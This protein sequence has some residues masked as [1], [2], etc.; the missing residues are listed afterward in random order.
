MVYN[1]NDLLHSWYE[2]NKEK[3]DIITYGI[4]NKSDIM[5][6][7]IELHKEGSTF[8]CQYNNKEIK[9]EVPVGGIHFVYNAICAISTGL[10][11]NIDIN[12]ILNGIKKFE[13]TKKRMDII[14]LE[15]GV[16]L[17][18]DTY[19]ASF[20]SMEATLKYAENFTENRKIAIL[21]DMLELGEFSK[22]LHEKVGKQVA[23]SKID[24]L[25]CTGE[26]AKS[27]IEGA[28]RYGMNE[29]DTKYFNS[30]KEI[31]DYIKKIW[32]EGDVILV[33]ASNGMKFFEIVENLK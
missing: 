33:K 3:L 26:N 22:E 19:N 9:V 18:N 31:I 30:K 20:E 5:A 15:N 28:K 8:I 7:Q 4:E 27:I 12:D 24:I 23:E 29:K 6:K 21:G 1:D 16:K 13:L 11:N 25:L 32:K 2:E 17:L 14:Q 10:E